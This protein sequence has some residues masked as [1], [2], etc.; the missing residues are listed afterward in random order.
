M[1]QAMPQKRNCK[2]WKNPIGEIMQLSYTLCSTGVH[3][4][5]Y[6]TQQA[7]PQKSIGKLCNW[8]LGMYATAGQT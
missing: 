7:M 5:N 8:L 6:I 3:I 1:Q 2:K 4:E